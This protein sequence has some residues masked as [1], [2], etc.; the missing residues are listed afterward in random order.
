M[1]VIDHRVSDWPAL[2][3]SDGSRSIAVGIRE[4]DGQQARRKG[5]PTL[6]VRL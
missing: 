4:I 3:S 2:K 1:E 6:R 5:L